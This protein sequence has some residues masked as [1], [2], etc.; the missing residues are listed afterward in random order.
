MRKKTTKKVAVSSCRRPGRWT[1]C[2]ICFCADS[3]SLLV[4]KTAI[5]FCFQTDWC[6]WHHLCDLLS[7]YHLF[8]ANPDREQFWPVPAVF[9]SE[10]HSFVESR[11]LWFL[12]LHHIYPATKQS[13][14]LPAARK[15]AANERRTYANSLAISHRGNS[16]KNKHFP[17]AIITVK[18]R[19]ILEGLLY[20]SD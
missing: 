16:E 2:G 13:A 18:L 5:S 3:L 10:Q 7:L 8:P 9:T 14:P 11:G 17:Y 6:V 15:I 12:T 1:A 19:K 20:V 4:V